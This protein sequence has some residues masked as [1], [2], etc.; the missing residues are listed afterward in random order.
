MDHVS[1]PPGEEGGLIYFHLS[2]LSHDYVSNIVILQNSMEKKSCG[3]DILKIWRL[4]FIE[5][6]IPEQTI[7]ENI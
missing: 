2:K 7:N 1:Q 4:K 3:R 6:I 5:S